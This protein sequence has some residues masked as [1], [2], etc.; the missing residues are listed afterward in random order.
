MVVVVTKATLSRVPKSIV[1]K[2]NCYYTSFVLTR[3][4][5]Y[6]FYSYIDHACMLLPEDVRYHA[7]FAPACSCYIFSSNMHRATHLLHAHTPRRSKSRR[8][9]HL[10]QTLYTEQ[11]NKQQNETISAVVVVAG[12]S[13]ACCRC[14]RRSYLHRRP[15]RHV[16]DAG[17]R[18]RAHVRGMI[19]ATRPC[20][21]A[22]ISYIRAVELYNL[23]MSR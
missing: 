21:H 1:I 12:S 10:K 18:R 3:S 5:C 4:G 16:H 2:G 8:G 15:L 19:S 14:R 23:L 6:L 20:M 7:C 13:C 17:G 11:Q 22:L 9:E